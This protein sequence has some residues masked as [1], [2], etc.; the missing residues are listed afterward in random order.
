MVNMSLMS[1]ITR[2][3]DLYLGSGPNISIPSDTIGSHT[4]KKFNWVCPPETDYGWGNGDLLIGSSWFWEFSL[5]FVLY[6][7]HLTPSIA[8]CITSDVCVHSVLYLM[9]TYFCDG[10]CWA[11]SLWVPLAPLLGECICFPGDI[12]A[13]FRHFFPLTCYS[14]VWAGKYG[15]A[16]FLAM[17]EVTHIFIP[18]VSSCFLMMGFTDYYIIFRYTTLLITIRWNRGEQE[19]TCPGLTDV[20]LFQTWNPRA[21]QKIVHTIP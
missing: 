14:A 11:V 20:F 7:W 15:W 5:L 10:W 2:L 21:K 8:N 9:T 3:L 17:M 16:S 4:R 19:I 12:F 13:T 6:S 1:R 18:L